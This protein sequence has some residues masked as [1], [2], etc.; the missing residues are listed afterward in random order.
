MSVKV[1]FDDVLDLVPKSSV[2]V[3]DVTVG[4][5]SDVELDGDKAVVTLKAPQGRQ[6]ARPA[7]GLDPP[8]QP[9]R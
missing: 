2:K 7:G 9:A 5:V 3:N 8:D 1:Q 4:Q 6:P